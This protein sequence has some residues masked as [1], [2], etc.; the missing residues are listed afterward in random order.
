MPAT[1]HCRH[2]LLADCNGE[3][4]LPG[5]TGLCIHRPV[6]RQALRARIRLVAT[7]RFWRRLLWGP[8]PPSA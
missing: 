2:C 1:R 8:G 3:C 7:L 6:P 4:M 5:D